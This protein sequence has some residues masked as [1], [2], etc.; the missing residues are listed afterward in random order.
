M[1]LCTMYGTGKVTSG[2]CMSPWDCSKKLWNDANISRLSME[3][4]AMTVGLG[5]IPRPLTGT[6]S[7]WETLHPMYWMLKTLGE[8]NYQQHTSFLAL[9]KKLSDQLLLLSSSH[10]TSHPRD[11]AAS[12]GHCALRSPLQYHQCSIVVPRAYSCFFLSYNKSAIDPPLF[13]QRGYTDKSKCFP[14][15]AASPTISIKPLLTSPLIP[16]QS[17]QRSSKD[18]NTIFSLSYTKSFR[19]VA[20]I[21]Q[22]PYKLKQRN[23]SVLELFII[24]SQS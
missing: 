13:H 19:E 3:P 7:Q 9:S 12:K 4:E 8:Q 1:M 23:Y 20:R 15:Q 22:K 21:T 11:G 2:L 10:Q 14:Q 18:L 17:Q 5:R 16:V 24:I 6:P